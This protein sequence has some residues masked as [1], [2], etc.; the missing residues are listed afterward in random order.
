MC[1][2]VGFFA[3]G[4]EQADTGAAILGMLHDENIPMGTLKKRIEMPGEIENPN[5]VKVVTDH[6]GNAMT[7]LRAATVP[8]VARL[9]A[10]GHT[11]TRARTFGDVPPGT[12]FWYENSNGLVE[13]AVANGRADAALGLAIGTLVTVA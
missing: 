3:K 5:V 12:G 9:T 2:I 10:N 11:L 1:G 6:Y 4:S 13:I 8:S 7:G